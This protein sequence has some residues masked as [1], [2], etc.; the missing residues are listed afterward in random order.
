VA[1]HLLDLA[2]YGSGRA[3]LVARATQQDLPDAVGRGP[4]VAAPASSAG[5]FSTPSSSRGRRQAGGVSEQQRRLVRARPVLGVL[6]QAA[7]T[8]FGNFP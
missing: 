4:V 8:Q 7:V 1:R 3:G 5:A 2:A 6:G